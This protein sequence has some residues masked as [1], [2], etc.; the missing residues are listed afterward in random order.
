MAPFNAHSV[1]QPPLKPATH[2]LAGPSAAIQLQD[3]RFRIHETW[4]EP[5]ALYVVSEPF[6]EGHIR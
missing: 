6:R 2:I 1:P 4:D 5:A 3:A